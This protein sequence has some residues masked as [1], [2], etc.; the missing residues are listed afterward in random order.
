MIK[1]LIFSIILS[2]GL[3][4]C[5]NNQEIPF[6]STTI[7]RWDS[8]LN[9]SMQ[10]WD[11]Y[12]I[13]SPKMIDQTS[14]QSYGSVNWTPGKIPELHSINVAKIFPECNVS[15]KEVKFSFLRIKATRDRDEIW[16][17]NFDP[18]ELLALSSDKYKAN[19]VLFIGFVYVDQS[20]NITG[21]CTK[22]NNG[23]L[24][25]AKIDW[26]AG[27]NIAYLTVD[28]NLIVKLLDYP[29]INVNRNNNSSFNVN[30]YA[31]AFSGLVDGGFDPKKIGGGL[32]FVLQ[33]YKNPYPYLS[34]LE[35]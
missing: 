2:I 15:N 29:G 23:N 7:E 4:S 20:V 3:F 22:D 6:F 35:K 10:F 1:I 26:R 34:F 33:Y 8:Q 16:G 13:T 14:V 12:N 27:W 24:L 11:Y 31:M 9:S 28:D 30:F 19:Q 5:N 32:E 18:F 21:K 17:L 25:D